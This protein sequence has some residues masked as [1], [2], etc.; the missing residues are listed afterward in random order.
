M[1]IKAV[2]LSNVWDFSSDS[3]T[4]VNMNGPL[5]KTKRSG[6]YEMQVRL[7]QTFLLHTLVLHASKN[8]GTKFALVILLVLLLAVCLCCRCQKCSER[9][10]NDS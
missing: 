1:G 10:Y 8:M 6:T 5:R 3:V 2:I 7:H 4:C 9:N